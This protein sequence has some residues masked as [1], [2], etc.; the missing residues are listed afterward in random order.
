MYLGF[1][2]CEQREE[3]NI[4]TLTSLFQH[5]A[6]FRES[7]IRV[8]EAEMMGC[9]TKSNMEKSCS[10]RLDVTKGCTYLK[11]DYTL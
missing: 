9:E 4:N 7:L 11:L 6:R 10:L 2:Q 3:S 5:L 8:S 1:F